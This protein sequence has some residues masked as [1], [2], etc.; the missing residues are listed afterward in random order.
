ML[1]PH[2]LEKKNNKKQFCGEA[3]FP[4]WNDLS[5]P[6]PAFKV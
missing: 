5:N 2:P 4:K 3:Q 1:R 6:Q